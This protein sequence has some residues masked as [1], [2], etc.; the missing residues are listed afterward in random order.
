VQSNQHTRWVRR[1]GLLSDGHGIRLAHVLVG[2]EF[3]ATC[4]TVMRSCSANAP[5]RTSMLPD[6]S[7]ELLASGPM[8][9]RLMLWRSIVR[10]V[11]RH[12]MVSTS[13]E[14]CRYST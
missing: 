5:A 10:S 7:N 3:D 14:R 1:R 4:P 6:S 11:P 13:S 12:V 8:S 9:L 2:V